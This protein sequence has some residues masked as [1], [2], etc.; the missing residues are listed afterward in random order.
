M[1]Y[2][3]SS[4]Y[5]LP[6]KL[7]LSFRKRLRKL[8]YT[9]GIILKGKAVLLIYSG[10]VPELDLIL[11]EKLP[12]NGDQLTIIPAKPSDYKDATYIA[13]YYRELGIE[14]QGLFKD[15]Y[16]DRGLLSQKVLASNA[17]YLMGGNTYEFLHYA[18]S[19]DLFTIL[20]K[21]ESNGGTIAAESA[22]SI[23]LSDNIATA[24]LPSSDVDENTLNMTNFQSMG[25]L[26]FHISPHFNP[27]KSQLEADLEELQQLAN[28]SNQ[29]VLLLEDGEGIVMSDDI[30]Q[31]FVGNA[32]VI[33]PQSQSEGNLVMKTFISSELS[34]S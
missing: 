1:L 8:D 29:Y 15:E 30:I 27:E 11:A 2:L 31:Q 18:R 12:S 9:L 20:T 21:L 3:I 32:K 13:D 17:V 22:G 5:E 23:I 28:T 16:E 7:G 6:A 33:K 10:C 4:L 24:S 14:A 26:S 19:V 34:T 25:R